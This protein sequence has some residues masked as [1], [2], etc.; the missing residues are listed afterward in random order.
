MMELSR[1]LPIRAIDSIPLASAFLALAKSF[2]GDVGVGRV[3]LMALL[4]VSFLTPVA[5]AYVLFVRNRFQVSWVATG[6]LVTGVVKFKSLRDS[7]NKV[8]VGQT[9][10]P[11][12]LAPPTTTAITLIIERSRPQPAMS[13]LSNWD[14]F[15]E[16]LV[17]RLK[18]VWHSGNLNFPGCRAGDV[19][20]VSRPLIKP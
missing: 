16:D 1:Q 5:T 9:V 11:V 19:C 4:A 7:A 10:D 14:I 2:F 20:S 15:G 13:K 12:R 17:N 6:S 8:L 18:L 3:K